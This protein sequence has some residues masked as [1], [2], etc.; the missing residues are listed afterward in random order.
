MRPAAR[1][2]LKHYPNEWNVKAQ[3]KHKKPI[4]NKAHWPRRELKRPVLQYERARK[5]P[6][7]ELWPEPTENY[8]L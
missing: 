2:K 8:K 1:D 7:K 4:S 6:A 3:T 5:H